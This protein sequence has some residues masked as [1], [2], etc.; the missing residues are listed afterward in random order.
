[1]EGCLRAGG[2]DIFCGDDIWEAVLWREVRIF[3]VE[4][5]W[6][7]ALGLGGEDIWEAVLELEVRI[8]G[9]LFAGSG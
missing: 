6:E 5:V 7:A 9:R 8:F 3:A 1:M 4:D 2:E